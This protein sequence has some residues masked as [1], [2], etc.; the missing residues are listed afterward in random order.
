MKSISRVKFMLYTLLLTLTM[1]GIASAQVAGGGGGLDGFISR[2]CSL[3]QPLAGSQS[4]VMSLIF[5]ISLGILVV[6][7]FMN[8]N[9]QGLMGWA[10]KAGL[11]IVVIVNLFT[12]P[13]L[14]GLTNPC[15]F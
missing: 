5:L 12:A 6:L 11:F 4:K 15:G 14:V 8:E 7:W 3:I 1:P 2:A 13:A 9:K 10:L